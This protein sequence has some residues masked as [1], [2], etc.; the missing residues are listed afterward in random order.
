MNLVFTNARKIKG[1]F[2][3][4]VETE[5]LSGRLTRDLKEKCRG[6]S[7][8]K[9]GQGKRD[10]F[11]AWFSR[12]KEWE[13]Q[14]NVIF[15]Y[16]M[17][18]KKT[19][20]DKENVNIIDFFD[21]SD[22]LSKS[23]DLKIDFSLSFYETN[24]DAIP[25]NIK[26][27]KKSYLYKR[28][29]ESERYLEQTP[30]I[31]KTANKIV[32][33]EIDFYHRARKIF[34][35]ILDNISYQYPPEDRGASFTLRNKSGDCGEFNHLFIALCRSLG[36]PAR[37]IFGAWAIPDS[38][39]H[40]HAWCEFYLEKTG[41]VPVDPSIAQGLKKKDD[42]KLLRFIKSIKNP[43]DYSYYFGNLDNKRI[44][45]CKGNNILLKN[46]PRKLSR[47]K[48]MEDCRTLGMQPTSAHSFIDGGRKGF[49]ILKTKPE[50][51]IQS[52]KHS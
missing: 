52:I 31:K 33:N 40:F 13:N 51:N 10:R 2:V 11:L 27:N 1:N 45:F 39:Q 12:L 44:I 25:Q 46:C 16:N 4:N 49:F 41:W 34:N 37:S 29:T 24:L 32:G 35:W 7:F 42:K 21:F 3:W 36:I 17:D 5:F 47:M 28:Y 20:E 15:S 22:R 23:F 9:S 18:P 8:Y 19:Y 48:F 43:Q 6:L 14:R 50:L 38:N 30:E 26:Y